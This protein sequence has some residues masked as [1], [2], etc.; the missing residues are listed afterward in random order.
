MPSFPLERFLECF[1][2]P[3]DIAGNVILSR[4]ALA[5]HLLLR[6]VMTPALLRN[7]DIALYQAKEQN[8]ERFTSL[9]R[10]AML[11]RT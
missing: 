10:H 4:L 8:G 1:Q 6:A 11:T 9:T 3:F 2:R 7:A 5:L